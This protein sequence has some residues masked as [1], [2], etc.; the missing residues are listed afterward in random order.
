VDGKTIYHWN[1]FSTLVKES[2]GKTLTLTVERD[3]VRV[4]KSVTPVEDGG[5]FVIGVEPVINLVFKKYGFF[6]S[7][8]L[9]FDKTLEA[10]PDNH[11][12]EK[13]VDV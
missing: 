13:T 6:Q 10:R 5:R 11:H 7:I 4:E 8:G 9:G 2:G 3:G 12:A 1:Q